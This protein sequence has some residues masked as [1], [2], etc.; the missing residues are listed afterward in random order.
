MP[1]PD[2]ASTESPLARSLSGD[3]QNAGDRRVR[4]PR[5]SVGSQNAPNASP[6]LSRSPSSDTANQHFPLNDI[7]YESSPAAV[8]QE[9]SNLQ[10]IRRMSMNVDGDPD[11]PLGA[12][13][14]VPS[15][16]P[17]SS[18]EEDDAA[19]LFWVPARLHP[20][21]APK[22]FKTFVEDRVDHIQRR[23]RDHSLSPEGSTRSSGS[24]NRR[25]S[26]LSKTFESVSDFQDGAEI[27]ERKR[28][29]KDGPVRSTSGE[30]SLEE[31]ETL[32]NDPASLVRKMSI[33]TARQ[34]FDTD[35]G[36]EGDMPL[37]PQPL[38]AAPLKRSTRTNYRR[39]S[40]RKGERV[41]FSRRAAARQGGSSESNEADPTSP[42]GSR[43]NDNAYPSFPKPQ[44]ETNLS[45]ESLD[46][47][48]SS[49][50]PPATLRPVHSF[51]DVQEAAQEDEDEADLPDTQ[52]TPQQF[53]SRFAS[54]GRTTAAVP[55]QAHG[56]IQR[57][58][59]IVE[60][61]PRPDERPQSLPAYS[62]P[63][64]N[65]PERS[66][67]HDYTRQTPLV[68]SAA[69]R[70]AS[71]TSG[72]RQK[73]NQTLDDMANNPSMMPGNSMSTD[74]LSFIPTFE[75]GRGKSDKEKKEER[76]KA[77]ESP[78]IS[79]K[80][81]W[82]WLLGSDDKDRDGK[83]ERDEPALAKKAKAKFAK[84]S[85]KSDKAQEAKS[86][87]SARLDV[88]SA[89]TESVEMPR[90]RES[91]VLDRAT[92]KLEEERK[93]DSQSRK[94]DG[95]KESSNI[96]SSLFGGKKKGD[97]DSGGKKPSSR[98]LSPEPPRR[99]LRP[100]IDY[101]WTR[102]SILEERAIYRMA[103]IKLANPRRALYSQ[104]LLSNFMYSYLAKVQQMHPQIQIPPFIQQKNQRQAEQEQQKQQQPEDFS[105]WQRYQEQQEKMAKDGNDGAASSLS[106][107]DSQAG[108]I[109][110]Y[111]AAHQQNEDDRAAAAAAAAAGQDFGDGMDR[112]SSWDQ[113]NHYIQGY[114][115]RESPPDDEDHMW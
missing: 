100:D 103:H 39:G 52:S 24:I 22:E 53:Q 3:R 114:D 99:I 9:L 26:M 76:K 98:G 32:V 16:A 48:S 43:S 7:D 74:A 68:S 86:Q 106:G 93:K 64:V 25:R 10:A 94:S 54:N 83:K 59:S 62:S 35:D 111:D 79:K 34:S 80:S 18:T 110:D 29:S 11:L 40:L 89:A 31:L 109:D 96:F 6:D 13:F 105:T 49:A 102:F 87:D 81:S 8:A 17:T 42:P 56:S 66:S 41:P 12:G 51:E 107:Y 1:G 46:K 61:P 45:R 47:S 92:L 101:N 27:L 4:S 30:T 91:L 71:R 55:H 36:N 73:Q 38:G 104:V 82:G 33:D 113:R 77:G 88:L 50:Q 84:M 2:N 20:E 112:Q 15:V 44:H 23:S 14:S 63:L 72:G 5:T 57:I 21:L 67:S 90:G 60:T 97:R 95:K 37:V 115:D 19:R 75:E 28:S 108:F 78:S 69:N 70:R 65:R 58:P 85:E